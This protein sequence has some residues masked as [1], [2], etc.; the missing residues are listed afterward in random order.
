M[1]TKRPRAS[2]DAAVV[3]VWQREVGEL[4]NRKFAHRL[5]ASEDLVLR[6]EI[7][8]KLEKHQGC[9]NT[10]SFNADGNI[11][12]SGS[13][14]KRIILWDWQTGHAKLTFKS[15]HSSNVFQ[16]KFMPYADD[17]SLITCAADGQVRHAQLLERGVE[18]RLLARHEGQAHKLA[19]EPGSPH[20]FYTCGQDGLVQHIDLRTAAATQLFTCHSIDVS[21]A[22]LPVV[23]LNTISIDPRN[24]NL[25]AVAGS[26]E[27]TRLYDIRKYKWDGSTDFGQPTDHFCPP[28]LIGDDQVGI[29]GLAFSDQSELLVS[30]SDEFIYLF[31]QDMGL[32]PNPVPSPS[33]AC[34]EA[35][36]VGPD[37]SAMEADE[38]VIPQVYKGHRNCE[39]V[40]GVSFFGPKSEYVVSGSDCGR[41]FIWKK[42]GELVRVMK[43]DKHVVNC[44]ES[45]PHTAVLA[46]SGIENDIKIWTPKAIDKAVLPTNIEQVSKRGLFHLLPFSAFYEDDDDDDDYD[47]FGGG[48]VEYSDDEGEEED[49]SDD[50]GE[51]DDSDDDYLDVY[52]EIDD[53]DDDDNE[54]DGDDVNE[55]D[56]DDVNSEDVESGDDS[57]CN[58]GG[59]SDDDSN[60]C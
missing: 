31:T 9:V 49:D 29:T 24:P 40:K 5:A 11:L 56:G 54:N 41:I 46:S 60:A 1:G 7:F 21:K 25:F 17:R 33:S 28:H 19:I 20:I 45:H 44:I 6:F 50:E 36:E 30:Y 55:N 59:G 18:T 39:T 52:D 34:S 38:K 12:V 57:D 43:A 14:D 47:C 27:Y 22:D 53:D 42:G 13:D 26:D 51:E 58:D 8:K 48:I 16:A 32:G 4:S 37:H 2:V 3:D 35:S 23:P 15:G 10:V